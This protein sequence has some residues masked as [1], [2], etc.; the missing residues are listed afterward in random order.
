MRNHHVL[1]GIVAFSKMGTN[2][3]KDAR[4]VNSTV[5]AM[6]KHH[7]LDTTHWKGIKS[8]LL[9]IYSLEALLSGAICLFLL[10]RL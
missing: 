3:V 2:R 7:K 1:C 8:V 9:L 4:I 6:M 5:K 10:L